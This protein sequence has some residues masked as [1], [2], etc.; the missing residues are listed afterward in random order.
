MGCRSD[1]GRREALNKEFEHCCTFL[2]E[3]MEK[4]GLEVLRDIAADLQYDPETLCYDA[5]RKRLRYETYVKRFMERFKKA[6]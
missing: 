3:M 6:A 5:E 4:Y 2:A 1:E